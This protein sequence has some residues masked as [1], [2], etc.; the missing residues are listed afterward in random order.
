M[1]T[2]EKDDKIGEDDGSKDYSGKS[3]GSNGEDDVGYKIKEEE[4]RSRGDDGSK[5]SKIDTIYCLKDEVNDGGG[6]EGSNKR[7]ADLEIKLEGDNSRSEQH[8]S[9]SN[10]DSNSDYKFKEDEQESEVEK[11]STYSKHYDKDLYISNLRG[12]QK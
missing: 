10:N 8:E 12:K 5:F 3:A 2:Q 6:N 4:N 11:C 7:E 1:Q 9:S